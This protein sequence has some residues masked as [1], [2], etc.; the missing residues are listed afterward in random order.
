MCLMV[1]FIPLFSGRSHSIPPSGKTSGFAH[2]FCL[3][4]ICGARISTW[5]TP[6][7]TTIHAKTKPQL[8]ANITG[9]CR[10]RHF[11]DTPHC[12]HQLFSLIALDIRDIDRLVSRPCSMCETRQGKRADYC[13]PYQFVYGN[14]PHRLS[15]ESQRIKPVRG[16]GGY[17]SSSTWV[18]HLYHVAW[19]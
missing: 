13:N 15:Q 11:V 6:S 5:E 3:G 8:L 1:A 19:L 2:K 9:L 10:R 18:A 7:F 16:G 17:G 4:V 12:F 14:I